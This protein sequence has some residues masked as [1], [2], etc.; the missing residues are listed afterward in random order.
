MIIDFAISS[1]GEVYIRT[2]DSVFIPDGYGGWKNSGFV[3]SNP[4]GYGHPWRRNIALSPN[5][6]LYVTDNI[7]S[8]EWKIISS[9]DGGNSWLTLPHTFT[10]ASFEGTSIIGPGPSL[11]VVDDKTIFVYDVYLETERRLGFFKSTDG[12]QSFSQSQDMG[13]LA[14][15]SITGELFTSSGY[16][17]TDLGETWERIWERGLSLSPPNGFAFNPITGETYGIATTTDGPDSDMR[18]F[19]FV[20]EAELALDSDSLDFGDVLVGKT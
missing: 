18:V 9:T 8:N 2:R 1:F 15:N 19:R 13:W 5:G 4:S 14:Y 17:S 16:R 3:S 7:D 20:P 10:C 6:T 11:T 12:G